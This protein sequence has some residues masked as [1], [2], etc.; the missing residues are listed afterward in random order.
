MYHKSQDLSPLTGPTCLGLL[1]IRMESWPV[2]ANFKKWIKKRHQIERNLEFE[3]RCPPRRPL[4]ERQYWRNQ[5]RYKYTK[6]TQRDP[7]KN[8]TIQEKWRM[9][10]RWS[11]CPLKSWCWP[12]CQVVNVLTAYL[13]S[14]SKDGKKIGIRWCWFWVA[15]LQVNFLF[16]YILYMQRYK[17]INL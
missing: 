1:L 8:E 13:D 7:F 12:H 6:G 11:L 16:Q 15:F 14:G 17:I 5:R 2:G 3:T 9:E 4:P 10:K